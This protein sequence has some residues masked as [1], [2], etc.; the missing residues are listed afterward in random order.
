MS[1]ECVRTK[2]MHTNY[3]QC[4]LFRSTVVGKVRINRHTDGLKPHPAHLIRGRGDIIKNWSLVFY[5][6]FIALQA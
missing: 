6:L 5:P 1:S 4:T 3:E 2:N